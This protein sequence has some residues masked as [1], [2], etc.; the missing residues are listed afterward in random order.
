MDRMEEVLFAN[1]CFYEAFAMS[2]FHLMEQLWAKES[3]VAC[4]HPGQG[5][6]LDREDIMESWQ[7]ILRI[8]SA[9]GIR[10]RSPVVHLFGNFA[11][12]VCYEE[13]DSNYLIATNIFVNEHEE[14]KM[15]HHQAGPT[16]EEPEDLEED[17]QQMIN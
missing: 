5:P 15:V 10:C 9:A 12:V 4:L 8:G 3:P 17:E 13:L 7:E 14:W 6:L 2:D 1:D 16:W 11:F